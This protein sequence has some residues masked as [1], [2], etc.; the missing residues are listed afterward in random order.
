MTRMTSSR[1]TSE[2]SLLAI[3]ATLARIAARQDHQTY[4]EDIQLLWE[5]VEPIIRIALPRRRIFRSTGR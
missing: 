1:G 2:G 5:P 3:A 4:C